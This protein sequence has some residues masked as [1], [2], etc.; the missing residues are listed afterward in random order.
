MIIYAFIITIGWIFLYELI[1][2]RLSFLDLV[3]LKSN[4][5]NKNNIAWFRHDLIINYK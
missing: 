3:I 4:W 1:K 2:Y 5:T